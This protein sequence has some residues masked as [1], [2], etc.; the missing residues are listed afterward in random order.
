MTL[1]NYLG[2]LVVAFVPLACATPVNE[3]PSTPTIPPTTG[4]E[5]LP[6]T[7]PGDTGL[8]IMPTAESASRCG[9]QPVTATIALSPLAT[10]TPAVVNTGWLAF[11]SERDGYPV[12]YAVKSDGSGLTK[13]IDS[14]TGIGHPSW[15]PDGKKIAF[16]AYSPNDGAWDI[17]VMNSDGSGLIN[18]TRHPAADFDPAWSPDGQRIAFV[19]SHDA[20]AEIYVM[21]AD[22]S[23]QTRLTRNNIWQSDPAWSPDGR[24][25]A[26]HAEE[27]GDPDIYLINADGTGQTQLTEDPAGDSSPAWSPD[28]TKITFVSDRDSDG[29]IFVMNADG[30]NPVNLTQDSA[31]DLAPAW[32][33]DARK[34]AFVKLLSDGSGGIFLMGADGSDQIKLANTLEGDRYPV[35]YPA[36]DPGLAITLSFGPTV[37][38]PPPTAEV[39]A[40]PGDEKRAQ[41]A[42][43]NFFEFLHN[44]QYAEAAQLYGGDYTNVINNNPTL[45]PQDQTALLRNACTYH[46]QCLRVKNV[47]K[48]ERISPGEYQFTVEFVNNAGVL[49]VLGPC[50]GADATQMP[51]Q[52]QF[53]YAVVKGGDGRFRVMGLPVYVP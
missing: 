4:C 45:D 52:S 3:V 25:I 32:S 27:D 12:L 49:F 35:W 15:S 48:V 26:F 13:L 30:S 36:V 21:N 29:D 31:W 1:R 7:T 6:T 5:Q 10:P 18:L 28:D 2:L 9:S 38:A 23:A 41:E 37:T 40:Q 16:H 20:Q 34:I 22:G 39:L 33:P 46:L 44:E 50:C 42:L 19:S 14:L 53:V 8:S 11:V 24:H 17:F 47:V 43:L 51:P